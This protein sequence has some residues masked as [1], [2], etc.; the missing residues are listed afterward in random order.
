MVGWNETGIM[1]ILNDL[2][3]ILM[4][5]I[6]D[7]FRRKKFPNPFVVEMKKKRIFCSITFLKIVTFSDNLEKIIYGQIRKM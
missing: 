4:E 5:N 2:L 1:G 6:A 3:C 7:Y